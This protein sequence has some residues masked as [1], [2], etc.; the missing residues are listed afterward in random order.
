MAI[1]ITKSLKLNLKLVYQLTH[2]MMICPSKCRL[3]N[4]ASIGQ[5]GCILPSSP[6]RACLHQN[7]PN[8][9]I[10]LI[11]LIRDAHYIQYRVDS[12]RPVA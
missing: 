3:S 5:K 1:M 11:L 2:R 4:S 9:D 10:R 6:D 12:N 7:L 8:S